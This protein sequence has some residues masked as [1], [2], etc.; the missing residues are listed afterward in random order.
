M[1]DVGQIFDEALEKCFDNWTILALAVEQGWGGRETRTKRESFKAEVAEILGEGAKKK[2]P[3]S[4]QNVDDV[5]ELADFLYNRLLQLFHAEADD[6]S[7]TEVARFC[8]QLYSTCR[9]GDATF[10]QEFMQSLKKT[11]LT[12]CQ[13]VDKIEYATEEDKLLDAMQKME[14]EPGD[15]GSNSD[16]S[17]DSMDEDEDAT[18]SANRGKGA[19]YSGSAQPVAAETVE[20]QAAPRKKPEQEEPIVDEDGFTSI[21]KSNRRPR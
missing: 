20:E 11:D 3:P 16:R 5:Q 2:R 9:A 10:A 19:G 14:V 21:V 17:N 4:Y 15:A 12:Q 6:G 8:L 7:D 1:V 13:G 18:D